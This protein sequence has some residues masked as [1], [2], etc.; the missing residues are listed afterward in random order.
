MRLPPRARPGC[1]LLAGLVA[2][3]AHAGDDV[4]RLSVTAGYVDHAVV[5]EAATALRYHG[6]L[7]AGALAYVGE[8]RHL[9]W[10]VGLG[11]QGGPLDAAGH[12][13]RTVT[14]AS[15][16][17]DGGVEVVEVPMRGR[18]LAFGVDGGAQARFPLA[19]DRLAL[20]VGAKVAWDMALPDGFA[21]PGLY[22]L[23]SLQPTFGAT[24]TPHPRHEVEVDVA[25][26]VVGAMTRMPYHQSVSL[27][28]TGQV[29]GM[30]R[31][32]TGLRTPLDLAV[33]RADVG[34]SVRVRDRVAVGLRYRFSWLSDQDPRPLRIA[35]HGIALRVDTR[36]GRSR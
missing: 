18:Q 14:F 13:G 33:V 32:G 24:W 34:W 36:L 17:D 5:D 6:A 4:H 9:R 22:S 12:P 21:R 28:E 25:H 29:A 15:T 2:P 31:Q 16:G 27:P 11:A 10:S 23:V 30:F 20:R 8:R 35:Q 3:S 26:A 19:S 1:A 7:G